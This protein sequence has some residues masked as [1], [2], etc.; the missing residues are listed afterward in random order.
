MFTCIIAFVV[1][2]YDF[3][4]LCFGPIL[5]ENAEATRMDTSGMIF[6]KMI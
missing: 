6:V 2:W 5:Y 3:F 1:I 4:L